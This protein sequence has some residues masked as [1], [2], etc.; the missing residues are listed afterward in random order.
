MSRAVLGVILLMTGLP[1]CRGEAQ[2]NPSRTAAQS[3]AGAVS[4]FRLTES[5]VRTVS[6]VLRQWDPTPDIE[7]MLALTDVGIGMSREKFEALPADSQALV[8]I[9]SRNRATK[10]FRE[11][12]QQLHSLATGSLPGRIRAA[13]GIPALKAALGRAG[14]STREFLPAFHA[15]YQ[16]MGHVLREEFGPQPPPAP[17]IARDNVNLFRTMSK[18]EQLWTSLGLTKP[19]RPI[20]S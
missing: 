7:A 10:K 15:Y 4:D 16:A 6:A 11:G 20:G 5:V 1:A 8:M 3:G 12:E 17:G 13:E 19:E 14:L 2:S 18:T 9:E